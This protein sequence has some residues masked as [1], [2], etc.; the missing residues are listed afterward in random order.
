MTNLNNLTTNELYKE[1]MKAAEEKRY[2]GKDSG[3]TEV[4]SLLRESFKS[5][6]QL[7]GYCN[8]GNV[9]QPKEAALQNAI[10]A[11]IRKIADIMFDI[12][13]YFDGT[14]G[15]RKMFE[16]VCKYIIREEEEITIL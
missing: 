16:D 8:C 13:T 12:P 14:Y 15:V 10:K 11:N 9:L 3:E 2:Y 6:Q 4:E 5:L 7:K 1:A